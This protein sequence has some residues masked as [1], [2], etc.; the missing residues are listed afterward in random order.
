LGRGIIDLQGDVD[1]KMIF[2][3]REATTRLIAHDSPDITIHI[4]S[5]GGSV[6]TGLDIYDFLQNYTG[7]ITGKVFGYAR[8]MAVLFC[9]HVAQEPALVTLIC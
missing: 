3:V 8:S 1:G 5:G 7:K 2:Y 4:T 9:K 6:D